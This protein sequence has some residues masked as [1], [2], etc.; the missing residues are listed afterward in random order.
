[1]SSQI[2]EVIQA[3][4]DILAGQ[5]KIMEA[6][7]AAPSK[8]LV[9]YLVDQVR[10]NSLSLFAGQNSYLVRLL[11]GSISAEEF[12]KC[13]RVQDRMRKGQEQILKALES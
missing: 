5:Q 10:L 11:S 1:M 7:E 6:L 3:Q 4:R 12:D 2:K 13:S 9:A 8:K